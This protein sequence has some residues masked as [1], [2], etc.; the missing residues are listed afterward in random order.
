MTYMRRLLLLAGLTGCCLPSA[1]AQ[2]WPQRPVT[3]VVPFAPGGATDIVARLLSD[4]LAPRLGQAVVVANKP[5][6]TGAVANTFVRSQQPDGY[7]LYL[8]TSPF[9]TAPAT[10]PSVHSYEPARDFTPIAQISTILPVLVASTKAPGQNMTDLVAYARRN[11][12]KVTVATTGIGSSDHLAVAKLARM[13]GIEFEYIPYKGAGPA[14]QDLLSG[15][16]DL[17][18]DAFASSKPLIEAGQIRALGMGTLKRSSMVPDIPTLS[19]S[20]KGYELPSYVGLLG[21]AGLPAEVLNRLQAELAVV[22]KMPDVS[23]KLK[24]LGLE[25]TFTSPA[26]FGA[27]LTAHVRAQRELIRDLGIKIE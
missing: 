21:P 18:M 8:V 11:P 10:Q 19:E 13:A 5:G 4:K 14:L 15:V 26:E 12:G 24:L 3:I 16:V 27:Y 17:K 23:E 1:W 7:T 6:G 22:M 2:A 20:V 25:P 9:S